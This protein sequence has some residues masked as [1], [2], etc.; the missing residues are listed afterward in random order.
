MNEL[1]EIKSRKIVPVIAKISSGKSKLL[2][3]LYN[4][5]FLECGTGITTKFINLLRYNPKISEPRFYHLKLEKEGEKYFFYK[6][7]SESYIGEKN[8]I[9]ANKNINKKLYK[10]KEIK[11]EDIF[12]MTEINEVPFIKDKEYLFEHDLCDI[13]G[14]TE[15]QK[16]EKKEQETKNE[17]NEKKANNFF[18]GL[19]NKDKT[20]TDKGT[21]IEL[22]DI[23]EKTE[24]NEDEIY[25]KTLDGY[26]KT[27]ISEIFK[28]IKNYIDGGI[29]ILNLENYYHEE[30]FEIIAQLHRVIEKDIVNFLV[31]L[32]KM[33][34]SSNPNED[35][36]KCKGEIIQHFPKCQT[37]N[38][39]LNTFIPLSVFQVES[40]LLMEKS[41]RH[42]IFYHFYNYLSK[43][44]ET[45]PANQKS[46]ISHLIDIINID[47]SL[48]KKKIESEVKELNNTKE[49]SEITKEIKS[50]INHI[51]NISHNKNNINLG[52]NEDEDDLEEEYENEDSNDNEFSN[53]NPFNIIKFFYILHKEKKLIPPLSK[54]T[55]NLLD[56]FS[57]ANIKL[58]LDKNIIQNS[59]ENKL[60]LNT[61]EYLINLNKKLMKSKI[62][63]NKIN[64]LNIEINNVIEYLNIYNSIF[65]PFLGASNSGKSTIINGIIGRDILP[66]NLGE[67]TKRGI[68][69]RY[70]DIPENEM[71]IR[72]MSF[73]EEKK[74]DKIYYHLE[75]RNIIGRGI[76]QVT[77]TLKGL[78]Y[79]FTD[80]EEDSFYYIETNIRL[81]NDLKLDDSLK[82]MIY[83]IDFPGYGTN[84]K[85]IK[86]KIYQ[87]FLSICNSF[88]FVVRNSVIKENS[89]KKIVESIF[90]QVKQ[91]KKKLYTGIINS[92]L[93][94]LNNDNSQ[95]TTSN[96]L[97]K[98]KED[99]NDIISQ[100][101]ETIDKK[102]IKICFFNAKFYCDYCNNYNYF[103]KIKE[104]FY[105]EHDNYLNNKRSLF[106][107]PEIFGNKK[108]N[109]FIDYINKQLSNKIRNE[110]GKKNIKKLE[111]IKSNI[112]TQNEI[113]YIFTKFCDLKFI[114]MND[115]LNKGNEISKLIFYGQDKI[116]ELKTLKNSNIENFSDKFKVQINFVNKDKKEELQNKID[117]VLS[118]LDDFFKKDFSNKKKNSK[119]IEEFTKNISDIKLKIIDIYNINNSKINVI[120]EENKNELYKL[121]INKKENLKN[122]LQDKE[123]KNILE[124]IIKEIESKL[125]K[126]NNEILEILKT[127]NSEFLRLYKEGEEIIK[128]FDEEKVN[129]KKF[130]NFEEYLIYSIGDKNKGFD[131]QIYKEIKS[132]IKLYD[133]YE[134]KGLIDFIK[135][136]FSDYHFLK[137]TVELLINNILKVV[138]NLI[139]MINDYMSIY[140]QRILHSINIAYDFI[141]IEFSKEQSDIWEEIREYYK[142]IKDKI[143]LIVS[144]ICNN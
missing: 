39:N 103:F 132:N 131:E 116:N 83:L 62:E 37:F 89:T 136:S 5:S 80:I 86:N 130:P 114:S 74:L 69:I 122:N 28:I 11:Y 20:K 34:L 123:N 140:I 26:D 43:L 133:I 47:K 99:I 27:Y 65:I 46:F 115:I 25:Y 57:N 109:S 14:L 127:I 8:I 125:E 81:F 85:F 56:Y 32:N 49:V 59:N 52:I 18:K 96:D 75:K 79:E 110:F 128:N 23:T 21:I 111:S 31:I 64:N 78:N 117:E 3:V 105:N 70:N 10:Q 135:S 50:I 73:V 129:L 97:E 30:N 29:I 41:F 100:N 137:N 87:K 58:K 121:L 68:V 45:P 53:I 108:Y 106:K 104:T 48:T 134:N 24:K 35:I 15:Y 76:K 102:N 101:H 139:V 33:D 63:I 95:S 141:T 88:I 12:Y 144:E 55:N 124:E 98:A 77:D 71:V 142:T 1:E 2:N 66:T 84:N 82:R 61:K 138:D 38:I 60:V 92:C 118:I 13:P 90:E 9:E 119:E 120:I 19:I 107:W 40:E 44:N 16:N 67:C 112:I 91:K 42:L 6:D 94:I 72:K 51:K 54:E 126:L 113:N 36:N 4:F 17:I 93:F 7:L 143:K 22:V